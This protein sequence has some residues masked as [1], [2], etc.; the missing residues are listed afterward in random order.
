MTQPD[1]DTTE[2][3]LQQLTDGFD[4]FSKETREFMEETRSNREADRREFHDFV[5]ETRSNREAD[6]REF[7]DFVEETRSN[8]EADRREFHDFVEETRSNQKANEQRFDEIANITKELRDDVA[9]LKGRDYERYVS[10]TL[11]SPVSRRLGLRR[12]RLVHSVAFGISED[13]RIR[14]E[15]YPEEEDLF[16]VTLSDAIVRG[17]YQ[18]APAY[19]VIELSVTIGDRDISRAADRAQKLEQASKVR[20]FPVAIGE[21]IPEP[22]ADP[23]RRHQR[24]PHPNRRV[25]VN[26]HAILLERHAPIIRRGGFQTRPYCYCISAIPS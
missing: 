19:A 17:T 15:D 24:H 20:T 2:T 22:P 5:V 11:L 16:E 12:P 10:H 3:R 9:H 14:L 4:E 1:P 6:R 7:H 23:R 13:F 8:R 25:S 21:H 26:H 18:G